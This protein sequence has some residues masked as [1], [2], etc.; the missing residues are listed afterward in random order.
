MV[1]ISWVNFTLYRKTK[2]SVVLSDDESTRKW[3][4][5]PHTLVRE[6]LF[7]ESSAE[8]FPR[9][10]SLCER[11]RVRACVRVL[12]CADPKGIKRP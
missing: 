11:T 5:V 10:C 1:L 6:G 7:A 12:H 4:F 9:A 2:A 3:V 8:V